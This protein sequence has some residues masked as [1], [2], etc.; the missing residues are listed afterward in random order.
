MEYLKGGVDI[1]TCNQV[2]CRGAQEDDAGCARVCHIPSDRSAHFQCYVVPGVL[3]ASCYFRLKL[4]GCDF[5]C[6]VRSNAHC[7]VLGVHH[8]SRVSL[9][10][11]PGHRGQV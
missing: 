4:L 11:R 9:H 2:G 10:G 5:Q 8:R 7:C 6:S 1:N 3:R